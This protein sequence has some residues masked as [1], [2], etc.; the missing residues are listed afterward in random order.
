MYILNV[1]IKRAFSVKKKQFLK[2]KMELQKKKLLYSKFKKQFPN[3]QL[4]SVWKF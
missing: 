2:F 4:Q 3:F 1:K